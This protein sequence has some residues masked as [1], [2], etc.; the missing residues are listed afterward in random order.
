[1]HLCSYA[2]VTRL[3]GQMAFLCEG[4]A[5]DSS[6]SS[7]TVSRK[8]VAKLLPCAPAEYPSALHTEAADKG[9]VPGMLGP[10]TSVAGGFTLLRMGYLDPDDGWT[11]LDELEQYPADFSEVERAAN[12]ALARLHSC[13]AGTA[14]HGDLRPPNIFLR[15]AAAIF[16]RKSLSFI[17]FFCLGYPWC[18]RR[19]KERKKEIRPEAWIK[20]TLLKITRRNIAFILIGILLVYCNIPS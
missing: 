8:L 19:K 15:W 16:L 12:D 6:D 20:E 7:S 3:R 14:V 11:R 4:D 10:T 1:M 9:C 18:P 2:K 17:S 5:S 13:L